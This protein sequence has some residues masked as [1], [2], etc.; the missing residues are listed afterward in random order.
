MKN[1]QC[2]MHVAEYHAMVADIYRQSKTMKAL[3][4]FYYMDGSIDLQGG[5]YA[6]DEL[7]WAVRHARLAAREFVRA[8][9]AK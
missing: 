3:L 1:P 9:G 8:G 6:I 2:C 7:Q 4:P 5:N